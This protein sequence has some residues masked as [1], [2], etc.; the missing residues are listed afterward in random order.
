MTVETD[1]WSAVAA[2]LVREVLRDVPPSRLLGSL[3]A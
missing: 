2:A 3:L 1:Q